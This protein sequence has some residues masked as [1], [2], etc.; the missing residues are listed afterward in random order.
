MIPPAMK[1]REKARYAIARF[2]VCTR[3]SRSV[4]IELLTASIPVYVPAP[5]E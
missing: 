4:C 3:G 5:I 1:A 2:P